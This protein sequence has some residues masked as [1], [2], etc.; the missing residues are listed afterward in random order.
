MMPLIPGPANDYSAIYT[1]LCQSQNINIWF[2][3]D[4]KK[5]VVSLDLDLYSRELMLCQS[6]SEMREIFV[7]WLGELHIVFAH[8]RSIGNFVESSGLDDLC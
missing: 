4:G 8:I 6:N 3:G 1:A 2:I 7:P 5:T